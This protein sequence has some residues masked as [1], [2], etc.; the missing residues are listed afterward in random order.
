MKRKIRLITK[1]KIL[2]KQRVLGYLERNT[3]GKY[4]DLYYDFTFV[5][6]S[7]HSYHRDGSEWIT[8]PDKSKKRQKKST[9]LKFFKGLYTLGVN[10]IEFPWI[11]GFPILKQKH[12][13]KDIL[14][15]VDINLK[16]FPSG[17]INIMVELLEPSAN[18]QE[19]IDT[20]TP[21]NAKQFIIKDFE[22]W[23]VITILGHIDNMMVIFDDGKIKL[24][25]INTR[26]TVNAKGVEYEIT[27]VK[28]NDFFVA[29]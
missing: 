19:T 15:E 16:N 2:G 5:G 21:L 22:P 8:Y 18:F 9:Q 10:A 14:Y 20:K 11:A 7:H 28:P 26:F 17:M 6:G 23:V 29:T 24:N 25:H 12:I 27:R 4:D 13:N 1:Q 3:N